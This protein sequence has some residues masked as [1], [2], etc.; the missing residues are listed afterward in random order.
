MTMALGNEI[1]H[2]SGQITSV[3][4][5]P[6]SPAGEPRVEVSFE[7]RG[8]LLD[9]ETTELGTYVAVEGSDGIMRGQG[10]GVV[11]TT[12]GH[13]AAWSGQG[14]GR[15]R[16]GT[17]ASWR[18]AIFYQTTSGELSRLNE[19]AVLF[20]F[21]TDESGKTVEKVFEWT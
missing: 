14:I 13:S 4:V 18:G 5:L 7:G 17:A 8:R 10:Q 20:E 6:P 12:D 21:E 11:M 2:G 9:R 3:R 19:V 1:G 15:P 16:G